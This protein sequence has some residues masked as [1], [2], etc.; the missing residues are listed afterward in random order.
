MSKIVGQSVTYKIGSNAIL[1]DVSFTLNKG[2]VVA[3]IG[4]NGAGKST[5]LKCILGLKKPTSGKITVDGKDVQ[6]FSKP[7]LAQ[8]MSYLPQEKKIAWP[9]QVK[10][11]VAL[12]RF[13]RGINLEKISHSHQCVLDE[14]TQLCQLTYLEHRSI[15]SLSGGE[16]ARVHFARALASEAPFLLADEPLSSLDMKHQK[17]LSQIIKNYALGGACSLV[18]M[19]E[20]SLA[21]NFADRLI[22]LKNGK[23][24]A[25]GSV[26]ETLTTE[27][28]FD[29]FEVDSKINWHQGS[30]NL[31]LK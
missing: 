19:H 1:E 27:R 28:I 12:G 4:P 6:S 11:I 17:A 13:G 30:C 2:E 31:M 25:I 29:V 8:H 21:V 16:L 5:L 22:W 23:L 9:G 7:H 15:A 20:L 18:V 26:K 10:D 14:V 24:I 3:L